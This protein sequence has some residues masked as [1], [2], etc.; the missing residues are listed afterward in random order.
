MTRNLGFQKVHRPPAAIL[1]CGLYTALVAPDDLPCVPF[2][3]FSNSTLSVPHNVSLSPDL[4][5]FRTIGH[6][7]AMTIKS[8]VPKKSLAIFLQ[9]SKSILDG[10][11]VPISWEYNTAGYKHGIFAADRHTLCATLWRECARLLAT[12]V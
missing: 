11:L 3:T 4:F 7:P 8:S 10:I 9:L 12:L 6:C 5:I 2:I 1:M